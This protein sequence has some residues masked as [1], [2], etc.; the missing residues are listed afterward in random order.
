M[1]CRR[2]QP[3][4]SAAMDGAYLTSAERRAVEAHVA[5]CAACATFERRALQV[6]TTVRIRAAEDVP[7]LTDR[8]MATVARGSARPARR[9]P[10]P[11]RPI[12]P[13]ALLPAAAAAVAGI[14]IGSLVVGGPWHAH[15]RTAWAS[16]IELGVRRAAPSIDAFQGSYTITE[17]GLAPGVPVRTLSM[18]LSF[19]APQRFRLDVHDDTV[20]PSKAWTPTNLTYVENMPAIYLSGPSGCVGTL[21]P[22]DCSSATT[23]TKTRYS[24]AAPVPADLVVPLATLGSV[25]GVQ[26]LGEEQV[27]GHDTVRVQM[28]FSR[29]RP[30]FPFLQLGGT[31]R[32]FFAEDVVT[33]WLDTAGW[34]P[35]RTQITPST[36][37][38]RHDW[39][40]RF[41]LPRE[42]PDT[43]ILDVSLGSVAATP[44][45]PS[46]F[47][48]K[49]RAVVPP[50][51]MGTAFG[52]TPAAPAEPAPL[53]L[54]AAIAPPSGPAAP[55]SVL[56]YADGLDYLRVA[57]DQR[58]SG[59]G[60]F[61]AIGLDAEQVTLPHVGP[62][63][64][65]PAGD[66]L[67]RRLSVHTP[68]TDLYIESN[69]SRD[70][71]IAVASSL[72]V[73]AAAIPQRW[74]VAHAGGL[75]LARTD[76]I[77]AL[78]T[79][80]MDAAT[81]ALPTGYRPTTA[82][83]SLEQGID[84]GVTVTFRPD[85]GAVG[86]P[87]VLHMGTS[88]DAADT[89]PDPERVSIGATTGRYSAGASELTW[90]Q[91]GRSWSVQGD[92]VLAQLVAIATSVLE[93]RG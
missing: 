19:L 36:D 92:L 42:S 39:E 89:A 65:E 69:L 72:D 44:P 12:R 8:I 21:Q 31:W 56:L 64:Y 10:R 60:P 14:V 40:M 6:R 47:R 52:Y 67:G 34:Y 50:S 84:V 3:L 35:V 85:T 58:W 88:R 32:P 77:D 53:S 86:S 26:V 29:A 93:A 27:D 49:G 45:D 87:V 48:I 51:E 59:P 73:R 1:N 2:A 55:T 76:P 54:V 82:T 79:M 46:V 90:T 41:G 63:L 30:L 66:G 83:R 13:R 71:L 61:G 80:G 17:R 28:P 81:L 91:G 33:V 4:V 74:R 9:A 24:A 37:P 7:D 75:T 70:Q 22:V 78:H 18:D 25:D 15:P 43:P 62:A 20:Y 11:R 23:I 5:T 68:T 57:E 38:G 16:E